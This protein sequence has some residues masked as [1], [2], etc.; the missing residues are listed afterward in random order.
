MGG[1]QA[2]SSGRSGASGASG[3]RETAARLPR[4]D[5]SICDEP[6]VARPLSVK[7]LRQ[8]SPCSARPTHAY[9]YAACKVN[10][11]HGA[12]TALAK[13]REHDPLGSH[14]AAPPPHAAAGLSSE[15][16]RLHALP[17]PPQP[18]CRR[19]EYLT[20]RL[21]SAWRRLWCASWGSPASRWARGSDLPRVRHTSCRPSSATELTPLRCEF[22]E[23]LP[24]RHRPCD[25]R[26]FAARS[27]RGG[28][29][30]SR[31]QQHRGAV[32]RHAAALP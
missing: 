21:C 13:F 32:Q 6:T 7:R 3:A 15:P 22:A 14:L 24:G 20:L 28:G 11:T 8:E 31:R 5:P 30:G 27:C 18:W 9:R 10:A 25:S 29:G 4:R 12:F 16:H 2:A 26:P 23:R 1:L 19:V 17:P